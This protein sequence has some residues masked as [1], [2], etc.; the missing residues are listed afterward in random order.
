MLA[1]AV[2]GSGRGSN[3]RAVL[4]AIDNGCLPGVRVVLAVSNNSDSGV[5]EI[6]G[7][8]GIPARHWSRKQ[9]A[10]EG[11]YCDAMLGALRDA[12]VGLIVLAGYMKQ[13]PAPIIAAYRHRILNIHPALLPSFGGRGMYGLNVHRA[14]LAAHEPLTGVTV[15][16]VDEEYDHGPIVVQRTVPVLASDTPESLAARVLAMEHYILPEAVRLFAEGRIVVEPGRSHV[17]IRSLQE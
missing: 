1:L 15:H 12:S 3:F 11:A 7:Q 5:L 17:H 8:H 10:S 2:F 4:G 6:A 9:Y 14:V 13:F 16:L